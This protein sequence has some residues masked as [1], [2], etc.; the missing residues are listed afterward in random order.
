[1]AL[2]EY[3]RKRDFH[4]TPEPAGRPVRAKRQ[5]AALPFVVQKH[6][7]RR[8]H[9]D[10]RLELNG[11]LLSWAVPKGPSLDPGEKRLAVHVEDQPLGYGG[12]EGVS[13]QGPDRRRPAVAVGRR[14]RGPE[15]AHPE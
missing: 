15:G 8:L 2:E 13:P 11:V 6:A 3:N 9:Y 10:F 12:A 5:A 1:M 4:K 7:A 14:H